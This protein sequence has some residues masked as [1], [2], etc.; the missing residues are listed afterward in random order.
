MYIY[1]Q[2]GCPRVTSRIQ[3]TYMC[4]WTLQMY[5]HEYELSICTFLRIYVYSCA[6]CIYIHTQ[7]Y[8]WIYTYRALYELCICIFLHICIYLCAICRIK[9]CHVGVVFFLSHVTVLC[10]HGAICV[11]ACIH[12]YIKIFIWIHTYIH[13]P[14]YVYLYI[15]MCMYLVGTDTYVIRYMSTVHIYTYIYIYIYIYMYMYTDCR[16]EDTWHKSVPVN[17]MFLSK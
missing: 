13:I 8:S 10:R 6:I 2:I 17:T 12:T 16:H 15:Y 7:E 11:Y 4:P 9:F 5:I 3:S 1:V 14:T